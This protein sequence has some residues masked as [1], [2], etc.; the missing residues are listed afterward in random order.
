MHKKIA[1][2]LS[3]S[4][5]LVSANTFAQYTPN[6]ADVNS[7]LSRQ[8]QQMMN[9]QM[10]ANMMFLNRRASRSSGYVINHPHMFF[11]T[12]KDGSTIKVT[13]KIN[14]DT[15]AHKQYL[16][17]VNSSLSKKDP[18]REQKIFP[19]ETISIA[20]QP[21]GGSQPGIA[22]DSCW[23]FKVESGHISAY[24]FLAETGIEFDPA[25]VVGIQEED[26]PI[27]RLDAEVLK[28]L[29]ASN[30]E[31]LKLIESRNYLKAIKKYNRDL[32]KAEK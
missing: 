2:L 22:A 27:R 11:V 13:S 3:I 4:A 8:D 7:A 32:E 20:R 30:S 16:H 26:G 31:S 10:M 9:N 28:K 1:L 17:Y 29:L 24:S 19:G 14:T 15:V 12:F 18:K 6:M 21:S 25:S 5:A 23:M